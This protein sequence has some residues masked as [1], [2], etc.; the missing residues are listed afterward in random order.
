M[1][2]HLALLFFITCSTLAI[3][4]SSN[5]QLMRP[6]NSSLTLVKLQAGEATASFSGEI[7]ISGTFIGRWPAG[8]ENINT[9]TPEFLLIPDTASIKT[10]PY[11]EIRNSGKLLRYPVNSIT[12]TNGE[13]ALRLAV[14]ANIANQLLQ[15]KIDEVKATGTFVIE[16][17]EVGV[18]CDAPWSTAKL[19]KATMPE[20]FAHKHLN[21]PETC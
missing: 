12:L 2:K 13:M 16:D 19:V 17:Y 1:V 6:D 20:Q 8:K 11:F 9:N 18:E 21:A 15:R 4:D 14:N 5:T 3:A 7:S 10:L